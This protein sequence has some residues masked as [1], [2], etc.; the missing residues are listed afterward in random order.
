[1]L[2][3]RSPNIIEHFHSTAEPLWAKE[4][5]DFH[6]YHFIKQVLICFE[7][8]PHP[9]WGQGRLLIHVPSKTNEA[10]DCIELFGR[11]NRGSGRRRKKMETWKRKNGVGKPDTNEIKREEQKRGEKEEQRKKR[12]KEEKQDQGGGE[13]EQREKRKRMKQYVLLNY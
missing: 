13:G 3:R 4:A 5:P 6:L 12:G 1:M 2:P 9:R 7:L 10:E 8:R 11:M